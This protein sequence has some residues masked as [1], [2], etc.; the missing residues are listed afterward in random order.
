MAVIYNC[1]NMKESNGKTPDKLY[2][3][4]KA[5]SEVTGAVLVL[6]IVVAFLGFLQ[7]YSVP[8]TVISIKLL[9]IYLI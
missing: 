1:G 8:K 9:M 2:A 7:V 6:A 3:N 4:E 5:V